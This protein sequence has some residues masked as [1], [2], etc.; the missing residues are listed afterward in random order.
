MA[1]STQGANKNEENKSAENKE[2]SS[3][4]ENCEEKLTNTENKSEYYFRE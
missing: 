2:P 3:P 4:I 1:N